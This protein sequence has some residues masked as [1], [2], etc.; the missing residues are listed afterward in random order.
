M[1]L[2]VFSRVFCLWGRTPHQ[3]LNIFWTFTSDFRY[4]S[5]FFRGGLAHRSMA[6]G[7][8]SAPRPR[9]SGVWAVA[10]LAAS[11][12]KRARGRRLR[13]DLVSSG[14]RKA[15]C[16]F[17]DFCRKPCPPPSSAAQRSP[18]AVH[19]PT[20]ARV[21]LPTDHPHWSPCH[22]SATAYGLKIQSGASGWP[23]ATRHHT[24]QSSGK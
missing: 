18:G 16:F 7:T 3:F 2:S 4:F 8:H 17:F 5:V 14:E 9:R 1:F 20:G 13:R 22:R 10:A 23:T 11:M 12:P 15:G 24:L 19:V 6:P 21:D